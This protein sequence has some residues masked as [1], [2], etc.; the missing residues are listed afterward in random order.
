M[1]SRDTTR[2]PAPARESSN[3]T[4]LSPANYAF[5]Q[6][7]IHTESGI[8]IDTDKQY[9]LESRLAPILRSQ[10]IDS[11]D[12]LSVLLAKKSSV[13][14]SKVVI[15]AMTTNETLFFR[16]T[17]M[18]EALQTHVLPLLFEKA[19]KTR[20]LRIWSAAASSGQ[21]AYS[22]AMMLLEMRK[23]KLDVEILGTDL[24]TQMLD[25]AR[26]GKYQQFEVTRGLP[27]SYLMKYFTRAGS[28]WQ[29]S[30]TVRGM[31][32][33]DQMDLRRELRGMGPFDL[34]MCRNVLIYF[35]TETKRKVVGAMSRLLY[36]GA[37][38]VLGCAE[39]V[40]NIHADFQRTAI[41]LSNFY[42]LR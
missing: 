6:H 9:L 38:L 18:F 39:T 42:S 8:V 32:R 14:L 41:G 22:L 16:D 26:E 35:D 31:V 11:L 28:D 4:A 34:I 3:P 36:P 33:F 5:L 10:N 24:S 13:A 25:R 30:E 20:K 40:I 19:G 21:E 37:I 2:D 15:D 17:A 1:T 29:L 12:A 23:T 7:F 27:S